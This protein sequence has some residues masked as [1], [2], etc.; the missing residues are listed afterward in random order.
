MS[1]SKTK[2]TDNKLSLYGKIKE[3][4]L[5][6]PQFYIG[7]T[8]KKLKVLIILKLKLLLSNMVK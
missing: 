1:Q 5:E 3:E 8:K 2:I 7:Y 6:I 4:E